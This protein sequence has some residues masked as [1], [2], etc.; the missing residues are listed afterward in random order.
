MAYSR[1][2]RYRDREVRA[3]IEGYQTLLEDRDTDSRGI[4]AIIA[5]TDVKAA[6]PHLSAVQQEVLL[7]RGVLDLDVYHAAVVMEKSAR[8]VG[9]TYL[10]ALER[11]TDIMNG[12]V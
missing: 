8:W 2:R 4:R 9:K 12:D 3:L 10:I 5:V 11:L 6:W 7:I 1:G